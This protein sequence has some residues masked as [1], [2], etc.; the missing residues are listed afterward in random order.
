MR[1]AAATALATALALVALSGCTAMEPVATPT[2]E[3]TTASQRRW[4][5]TGIAVPATGR[6]S[7]SLPVPDIVHSIG[8]WTWPQKVIDARVAARLRPTSTRPAR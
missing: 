7:T 1:P 2:A 4:P 6:N 3:P 5:G 8:S